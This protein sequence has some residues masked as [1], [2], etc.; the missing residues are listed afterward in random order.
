MDA[1]V[2]GHT[3]IAVLPAVL[4]AVLHFH[5]ETAVLSAPVGLDSEAGSATAMTAVTAETVAVPA[6]VQTVKVS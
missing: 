2:A 5:P 4:L 1:G 6:S 3:V